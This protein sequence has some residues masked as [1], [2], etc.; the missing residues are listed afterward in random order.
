MSL[1]L[2]LYKVD[3][4]LFCKILMKQKCFHLLNIKIFFNH[5]IHYQLEWFHGD[6][7]LIYFSLNK[8]LLTDTG[9]AN[10]LYAL[11]NNASL[12]ILR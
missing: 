10:L 8:N 11:E 7:F 1:F 4:I 12:Q 2:L 6:F 9:V 3:A 5:P